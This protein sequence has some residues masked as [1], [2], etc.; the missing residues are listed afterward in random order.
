MFI[1]L[2]LIR[3]LT[4]L[5][6]HLLQNEPSTPLILTTILQMER[7]THLLLLF[8]RKEEAGTPYESSRSYSRAS[9]SVDSSTCR[10][11][12]FPAVKSLIDA[13]MTFFFST[14]E[15]LSAPPL[16]TFVTP[17]VVRHTVHALQQLLPF[18]ECVASEWGRVLMQCSG[19]SDEQVQIEILKAVRVLA[20]MISDEKSE[21]FRFIADEVVK[22]L[23]ESYSVAPSLS[24]WFQ[25]QEESI[26]LIRTLLQR[27]CFR[28]Y[29]HTHILS[30]L[31]S[32]SPARQLAG[33]AIC[34]GE[35]IGLYEGCQGV[36]TPRG[37]KVTEKN[38]GRDLYE[39]KKKCVVLQIL[40]EH[41]VVRV[42]IAGETEKKEVP[43]IAVDHT[44][45]LPIRL[46]LLSSVIISKLLDMQSN[47]QEGELW[48][49]CSWSHIQ[50][51]QRSFSYK[52]T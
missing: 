40:P 6:H 41:D 38:C 37:C 7:T 25:R 8:C 11:G 45:L 42:I 20:G 3:S 39:G 30:L 50:T 12:S 21:D 19:T 34:G 16:L 14:L 13:L 28:A 33:V 9:S 4:R 32:S 36:F 2:D 5:F 47:F 52:A 46:S 48:V 18:G 31:S 23:E 1:Q 15:L 44:S 51:E 22:I 43:F 29:L 27:P 35:L 24:H 26:A 49:F 17:D 10:N